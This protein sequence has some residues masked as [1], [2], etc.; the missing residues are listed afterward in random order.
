[1]SDAA[2]NNQLR[3]MLLCFH[4]GF[5][6][7]FLAN[8]TEAEE[9]YLRY[10]K[11]APEFK[12][13]QQ[14]EK[15]LLNKW[16]RWHYMPWRYQWGIG[17][18]LAGGKFCKEYGFTGAFADSG[19]GPFEWINKWDLP[20][21]HDH[22]A[23]KG[24][25]YL[26]GAN[27]KKTVAPFQRDPNAIRQGTDGLQPVDASLKAKAEKLMRGNIRNIKKNTDRCIAYALDDEISWGA[28]V[29]PLCWRIHDQD[30][31]YIRWLKN[32]YGD[33]K[34]PPAAFVSFDHVRDQMNGPLGKI[35]FSPLLDRM[36]YNDSIWANL[37][38]HLVSYNNSLDPEVPCGFV[39]GQSPNLWGGFDYA[40]LMKK[41]QFIEAYDLGSAQEIVRS[42]NPENRMPIVTTHFHKKEKGVANDIWQ[43]W[44]YFAHG[45]RG[46]IGWVEGWFDGKT[47]KPWLKQYR[48]TLLEIS[49]KHADKIVG[50]KWQHD[51]IAIYYSHPSIQVSWCLD[52]Q[53]HGKTWVNRGGDHKLGTTHNVRKAWEYLLSDAGLQY[54]YISYDQVIKQG[55]PKQYKALIL[56]ACYAL[57]DTEAKRIK[58]FALAGGTVIAD[59]GC[60]LFDQHG[61]AR[62]Q[63]IL[64]TLF[65]VSHDG[66]ETE[67][68][69][70]GEKLWVETD[71]DRGFY[72]KKY[73]ELFAT[74][75]SPLH[76]GFAIAEHRLPVNK[77][78]KYA[79][80]SVYYLN[81]SP[82]RYL[83]Y[84]QEG[85]AD[86]THR[87]LF[88]KPIQDA[89]IMPSV[90]V[91]NASG[92][93]PRDSE[94]T[95][96]KKQ[97]RTYLFV[98]QNAHVTGSALGGGGAEGLG[99]GTEPVT[100]TFRNTVKDLR[101]ERTGKKLGSGK[102]FNADFNRLEAL[103]LSY[104]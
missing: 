27:K 66:T 103:F 9:D 49:G 18:G 45:N 71:Q 26:R 10:V 11:T 13:V 75:K 28:F 25:L 93:P 57:S 77:M 94:V 36:T 6:L 84:R 95:R 64:D 70:F 19:A 16:D 33:K 20:F 76:D 61:K 58:Q 2:R 35:D 89:G 14:D 90:S 3:W 99:E 48:D 37:I 74:I 23:G 98:I 54:N 96:W 29:L 47:P 67:K 82:Q 100:I 60:G 68:E 55:V 102:Q 42:F 52:A 12:S 40:K 97:G 104:R 92:K 1:M 72:Y 65:G 91:L 79:K 39:G 78:R 17:T 81:L 21:Y 85:V 86:Q 56:P 34:A 5:S 15:L 87:N 62:S 69:W 22:T 41:V 44:Y 63:G 88:L 43:T 32:Y 4:C 7:L 46:M 59:F 51:G 53:A 80:G 30:G 50:A 73:R 38:G 83:E 8:K 31:D 24:L 101:N